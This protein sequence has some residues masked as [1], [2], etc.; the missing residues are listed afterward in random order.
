MISAGI[1]NITIVAGLVNTPIVN[2]DVGMKS[3]NVAR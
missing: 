2:V 3:N 1:H